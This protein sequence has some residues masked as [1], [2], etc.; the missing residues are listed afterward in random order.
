MIYFTF[1]S[2]A[3]LILGLVNTAN[4]DSEFT[5]TTNTPLHWKII[6]T[7][8]KPTHSIPTSHVDSMYSAYTHLQV[9]APAL[10][11]DCREVYQS[12]CTKSGVYTI[13]PGCGKPFQVYCDMKPNEQY[14]VFQRRRDGSK[15]FYRGW[16]D[17]VDGFGDLKREFWM[18]LEKLHCLTAAAPRTELKI[19]LADFE[20]N[21]KYAHYS[22][23]SIGNSG[24]NYTLYISGYTG[25][26]GDI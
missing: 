6:T 14:I 23:F 1:G 8:C 25:N 15:D 19:D 12:V 10:P 7:N 18:G 26:A 3:I 21:Y 13:D 16:D 9:H 20:G 5:P 11:R 2:A 4:G 17:Y 22:F 24:T